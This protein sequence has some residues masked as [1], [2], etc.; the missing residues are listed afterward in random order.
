MKKIICIILTIIILT[1]SGVVAVNAMTPLPQ[2]EQL[3]QDYGAIVNEP[4]RY[5]SVATKPTK[6]YYKPNEGISG[7]GLVI[8][9]FTNSGS[10]LVS[11]DAPLNEIEVMQPTTLYKDRVGTEKIEVRYKGFTT[12]YSIK[13]LAGDTFRGIKLV[14]KPTNNVIEV[15]FK[16]YID[17]CQFLYFNGYGEDFDN[18]LDFASN[19]V[20]QEYCRRI[21]EF[22]NTK[23][24]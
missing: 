19:Y 12:G 4:I 20:K 5:I 3:K 9:V 11:Y 22:L 7:R 23:E 17:Y 2:S 13:W 24:N 18:G 16:E 1:M 21:D 14:S 8:R 15:N 6:L 10:Y